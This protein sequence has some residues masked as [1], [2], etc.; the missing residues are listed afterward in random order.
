[1]RLIVP[2]VTAAYSREGKQKKFRTCGALLQ[3]YRH[4]PPVSARILNL[5]VS[6]L[7][8]RFIFLSERIVAMQNYNK[9]S[10]QENIHCISGYNLV[11][12][13]ACK[14]KLMQAVGLRVDDVKYLKAYEAYRNMEGMHMARKRI[15]AFIRQ[16][17]G[18]SRTNMQNIVQRFEHTIDN[19]FGDYGDLTGSE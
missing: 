13:N 11:K 2:A 15:Y 4:K 10:N 17:F 16:E 3:F 14:L 7:I 8:R 1:M 18:I 19:G 9:N 12:L 5:K 6:F